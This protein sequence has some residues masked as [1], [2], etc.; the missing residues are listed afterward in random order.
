MTLRLEIS[1]VPFG[2]EDAKKLL[3]TFNISNLGHFNKFK[4]Y[5]YGVEVDKYKTE[6]Y[7]FFVD[8]YREDGAEVLAELVLEEF[9][10]IEREKTL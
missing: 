7:D 4:E 2:E 6:E 10:N 8:H 9:S 5:R 3:R 1:I